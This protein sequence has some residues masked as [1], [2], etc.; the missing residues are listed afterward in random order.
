MKVRCISP[1][2]VA[3]CLQSLIDSA[4]CCKQWVSRYAVLTSEDGYSFSSQGVYPGNIAWGQ[5]LQYTVFKP[6]RAQFVRVVPVAWNGHIT[7]RVDVLVGDG[8]SL[9]PNNSE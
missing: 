2:F 9:E 8:D 3:Y 5:G 6:V 4:G 1:R 7:M